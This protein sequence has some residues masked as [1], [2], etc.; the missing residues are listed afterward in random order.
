M[1][2]SHYFNG[3]YIWLHACYLLIVV[4]SISAIIIIIIIIIE[5]VG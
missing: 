2:Y 1:S 5:G 4:I 3:D